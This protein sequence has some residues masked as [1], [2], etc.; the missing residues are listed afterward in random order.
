MATLYTPAQTT[1]VTCV[2]VRMRAASVAPYPGENQLQNDVRAR[3]IATRI[4]R[5]YDLN[6]RLA[7]R[8]SRRQ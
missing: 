7:F 6:L 1:K 3:R 2:T 5:E 8:S 4:L